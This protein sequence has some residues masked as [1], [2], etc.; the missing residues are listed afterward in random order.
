MTPKEKA[1]EL[2]NKFNH[3]HDTDKKEYILYQDVAESIRCALIVVE[4]VRTFHNNLFYASKNSI[5]DIYLDKVKEEI[6]KY[7]NTK[8]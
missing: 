8:I 5:F 1:R 2:V 3:F 4:E 7:E 6:E